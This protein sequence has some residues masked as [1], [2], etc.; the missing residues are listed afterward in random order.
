M[1]QNVPEYRFQQGRR[2]SSLDTSSAN[3]WKALADTMSSFTNTLSDY[4]V[5]KNREISAY[6][7]SREADIIKGVYTSA[8]A[9]Q[10]NPVGY[11]AGVNSFR[12][13]EIKKMKAQG[14][15]DDYIASFDAMLKIKSVEYGENVARNYKKIFDATKLVDHRHA[16]KTIE[17]D[18]AVNITNAIA[19]WYKN[20]DDW[21]LNG[22]AINDG[23][24]NDVN[25]YT[26]ESFIKEFDPKFDKQRNKLDGMALQSI[27]LGGSAEDVMKSEV[28]TL[29]GFILSA[30]NAEVNRAIDTGKDGQ[31]LEE[32][33]RN[34]NA[35]F[36]KRPHLLAIFSEK[37]LRLNEDQRKRLLKSAH[38]SL[39]LYYKAQ[40]KLEKESDELELEIQS[41]NFSAV[42]DKILDNSI[43]T[44]QIAEMESNGDLSVKDKLTAL[45]ILQGDTL[46]REDPNV[47]AGI[48]ASLN[49]PSADKA[50]TKALINE[51]ISAG[52]LRTS[53]IKSMYQMV[54]D[55]SLSKITSD[56]SYQ[57]ARK[58][59]ETEFRTTGPLANYVQGESA[60][61]NRAIRELYT[62]VRDG[63]DPLK[64]IDEIKTTH[65]RQI[66]P[67]EIV[68]WSTYWVG[69]EDKPNEAE[70]IKKIEASDNTQIEKEKE[71]N[72]LK[73][74][75]NDLRLR[76]GR[77]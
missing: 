22:T 19:G 67:K 56:E 37:E 72:R 33:R 24:E 58:E 26:I 76:Q 61:I 16:R 54:N 57:L 42:I 73:A 62:R 4:A 69:T 2:V 48:Y 43:T 34:P 27:V 5:N 45:K 46:F 7:E 74:Y 66:A 49:N 71:I 38:E 77:K 30:L 63:E 13:L 41:D 32:F 40:D 68:V 52:H 64:I 15:G 3:S 75:M 55:K 29:D 12:E 59:I 14:L 44:K 25:P 70:T 51:A 28:A 65:N 47:V 53:T 17:G 20:Q 1:A 6:G 31:V 9:N 39:S 10:S 36:K 60:N 23:G 50:T 11:E 18:T 8:I 21:V 35:F